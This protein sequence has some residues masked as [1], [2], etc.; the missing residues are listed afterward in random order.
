MDIWVASINI[1]KKQTII[2][3]SMMSL[4]DFL[5]VIPDNKK[6]LILALGH[7]KKSINKV[8]KPMMG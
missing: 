3:E 8:I 7:V 2:F 5:E 4:K 6:Q 1:F